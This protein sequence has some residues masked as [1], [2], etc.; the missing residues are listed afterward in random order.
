MNSTAL[1]T[2]NISIDG[3][4]CGQCIANGTKALNAVAGAEV[5]SVAIGSAKVAV[6]DAAAAKAALAAIHGAGY[7][8]HISN[9]AA[10]AGRGGGG[11]GG[12]WVLS[13]ECR[14]PSAEGSGG[15]GEQGSRGAGEQGM[16]V[17]ALA[18]NRMDWGQPMSGR[19][20]DVV[21]R[22]EARG[23]ATAACDQPRM[24]FLTA[25]MSS[26]KPAMA[27]LAKIDPFTGTGL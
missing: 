14:V 23:W 3:M 27:V 17:G 24:S 16:I 7:R 12:C 20:L 4:S 11:G 22:R 15:A 13:A 5:R 25:A 9:S 21:G 19:G 2:L 18:H 26:L 10:G 8:A 1:T 6:A